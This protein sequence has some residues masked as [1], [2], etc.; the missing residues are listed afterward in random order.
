MPSKELFKKTD[1]AFIYGPYKASY[2]ALVTN[3]NKIALSI[4][5]EDKTGIKLVD[6]NLHEI[7]SVS[8]GEEFYIS[9]DKKASVGSV[10]VGLSLDNVVT[11]S[12]A[13]NRARIYTPIF[14]LGQN[15]LSGG[16]VTNITIT[17]DLTVTANA[18]TGVENIA[19]LLMVTLVAFTLGYLVL[20]YKS[21]PVELQ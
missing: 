19:L 17:G 11:F 14:S 12:P 4:K 18:K 21:K 8:A 16:K 9:I 20:S 6:K 1:T 13:S 2:N 3:D 7:A 15:A 5:N 10:A